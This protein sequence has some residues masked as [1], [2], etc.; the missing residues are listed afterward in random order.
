MFQILVVD[1][2]KNTRMLLKA[3]LEAEN[4]KVL[5]AENGEEALAVMDRAHIF[6][7]CWM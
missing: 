5:T 2:D 7:W 1:D 3:V 4:Y 6:W